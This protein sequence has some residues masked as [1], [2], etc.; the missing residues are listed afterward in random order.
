MSAGRDWFARTGEASRP[1]TIELGDFVQ[2]AF[3]GRIELGR[4]FVGATGDLS[5]KLL[6][7][8]H[9]HFGQLSRHFQQAASRRNIDAVRD[10]RRRR[11]GPRRINPG[12]VR[13]AD[14]LSAVNLRCA[15]DMHGFLPQG[16]SR[17]PIGLRRLSQLGR[18][19]AKH[20]RSALPLVFG[21]KRFASSM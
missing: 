19:T 7:A 17:C 1:I 18:R 16:L 13:S 6:H 20:R 2:Q 21:R 4:R 14:L 9:P 8:V 12:G 5:A 3:D 15:V 10:S 11:R